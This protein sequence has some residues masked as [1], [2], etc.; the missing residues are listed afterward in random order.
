MIL[1]IGQ[2]HLVE[3]GDKPIVQPIVVDGRHY[4]REEGV[5]DQGET[6]EE[7]KDV[8]EGHVYGLVPD[9]TILTHL[10]RYTDC[11]FVECLIRLIPFSFK[12]EQV[13]LLEERDISVDVATVAPITQVLLV[14]IRPLDRELHS[15]AEIGADRNVYK[16]GLPDDFIFD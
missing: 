16:S 12:L 11:G 2:L 7:G 3:L 4:D 8:I 9:L 13:L 10:E 15:L 14:E 1:L 6:T 5:E